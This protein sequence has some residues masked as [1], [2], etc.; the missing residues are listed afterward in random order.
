MDENERWIAK[1]LREGNHNIFYEFISQFSG[2][3]SW[4]SRKLQGRLI[5]CADSNWGLLYHEKR[6]DCSMWHTSLLEA[7]C[8]ICMLDVTLSRDNLKAGPSR[9]DQGAARTNWQWQTVF[10]GVTQHSGLEW[11]A[12][13]LRNAYYCVQWNHQLS[14][15]GVVSD[16][17]ESRKTLGSYL[18]YILSSAIARMN[19]V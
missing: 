14:S 9:K 2:I 12:S 5:F 10:H 18:G 1:D 15:H 16:T 19:A 13:S 7:R 17:H 6:A 11:T 8:Y 4:N 3:K